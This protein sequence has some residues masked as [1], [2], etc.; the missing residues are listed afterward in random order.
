MEWLFWLIGIPVLC[1]GLLWAASK[2]TFPTEGGG[3][4]ASG[5]FDALNAFYQ[6]SGMAA[7]QAREEQKRQVLESAQGQDKDPLAGFPHQPPG[8][9]HEAADGS[10]DSPQEPWTP[11]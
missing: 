2:F 4:G 1:I 11:R 7:Q 3:D 6:P 8:H 9:P 5:F 10:D